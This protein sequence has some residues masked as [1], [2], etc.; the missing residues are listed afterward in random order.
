[1][2][3]RSRSRKSDVSIAAWTHEEELRRR[4]RKQRRRRRPCS[5]CVFSLTVLGSLADR[6]CQLRQTDTRIKTV[7]HLGID[8]ERDEDEEMQADVGDDT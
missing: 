4:R 3:S 2:V 1:M 6:G 7:G 5:V 8:S